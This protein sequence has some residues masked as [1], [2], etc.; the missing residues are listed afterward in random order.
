MA[1]MRH[2]TSQQ[3]SEWGRKGAESRRQK[4]ALIAAA[5]PTSSPSVDVPTESATSP[6]PA[7]E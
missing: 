2:A 6:A 1:R 7:S 3:L 4:R 5:G